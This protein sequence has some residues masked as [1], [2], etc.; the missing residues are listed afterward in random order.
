MAVP[1]LLLLLCAALGRA[2]AAATSTMMRFMCVMDVVRNSDLSA[3]GR[4][5]IWPVNTWKT[6]PGRSCSF[7]QVR[8][9]LVVV[10]GC[11]NAESEAT[12]ASLLAVGISTVKACF[13]CSRYAQHFQIM[14]LTV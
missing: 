3:T 9:K 12:E 10:T 14:H 1:R 6:R 13:R 7:A 4:D 11:N 5:G 2:T 8:Q